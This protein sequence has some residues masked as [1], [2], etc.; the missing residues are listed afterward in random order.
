MPS[1]ARPQRVRWRTELDI[2]P[3]T[4]LGE[5]QNRDHF[6]LG[7]PKDDGKLVSTDDL[8]A[9]TKSSPA[10]DKLLLEVL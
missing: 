4:L 2:S 6:S 3:S 8:P 7:G 5:A 10:A 1:I 9:S